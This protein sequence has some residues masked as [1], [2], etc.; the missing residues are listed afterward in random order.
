MTNPLAPTMFLRR[1]AGKTVPLVLVIT[2]AVMLIQSIIALINSIP[3]SIRTIYRYTDA[4]LGVSPRLD[5]T[6]TP[7]FVKTLTTNPPV[8]IEKVILCRA[9]G[10]QVK[11]IVGKWPFAVMAMERADLDYYLQRQ[12][13]KGITGRFPKDGAPEMII[14]ESVARNLNLK[15]GDTFLKPDDSENFSRMPVKVVGIIKADRWMMLGNKQYFADTQPIPI[16]F[17][18][19]FTKDISKQGEY[20]RWAEKKMKGEFA[21]LFAFHQ[22]EKQSSEMFAVLYKIINLVIGVLVIVIT[23]MMGM[24]MN[25]YQSQRLVEF[26]LLQAIGFT[27]QQLLKRVLIESL[28]VIIGGWFVGLLAARGVL[29]IAQAMLMAP[30]AFALDVA[31]RMALTYTVPVPIAILLVA[32]GTIWLRFRNFDPVAVVER[33]LV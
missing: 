2:L 28:I 26:G 27:K 32:V 13:A 30:N 17:A 21:Q 3:L 16:D 33:R 6:M 8:E 7:T 10:A 14:S 1:N 25:I 19:I 12:G 24:L 5:P 20:D 22:I 15:L 4:F 11:S 31:D 18:L 9:S 23:T 29:L